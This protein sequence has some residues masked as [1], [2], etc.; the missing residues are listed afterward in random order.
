MSDKNEQFSK[1]DVNRAGDTLVKN[2]H[3]EQALAVFEHW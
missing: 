2:P 3:D 1:K